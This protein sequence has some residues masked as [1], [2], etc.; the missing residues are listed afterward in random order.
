MCGRYSRARRD[1]D[2]VEPL[3]SDYRGGQADLFGPRYNVSPGSRQVVI[4]P[5]GPRLE[6]WGYRPAWAVA[7]KIPMM[8]NSRLDKAG[9]STWKAMWKNR[10]VIVPA[11]GWYEWI[12]EDGKKQPYFIVAK[13]E[14]P[15]FF[16]GLSS[17]ASDVEPREGDGFVIVTSAADG[18][19]LD[20]HDRRPLVF[21]AEAAREWLDPETT[22]EEANHL[23]NTAALGV[24]EFEWF[25]VS[26]EVN[27][28]GTDDPSFNTPLGEENGA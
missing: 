2:Y 26:R 8:I 3:M 28:A 11:D 17:V 10:R 16:L 24:E 12:S 15:L 4:Y 23:A 21:D 5:D 7:R 20:V 6:H 22:F 9:T 25:R 13:D 27:R 19:M 14:R 1:V 18:G